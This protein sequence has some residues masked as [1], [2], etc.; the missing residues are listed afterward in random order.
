MK[1]Q[2]KSGP[3]SLIY[4]FRILIIKKLFIQY[5]L[6]TPIYFELKYSASEI[7]TLF[8]LLKWPNLTYRISVASYRSPCI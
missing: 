4:T 7:K 5:Y 6:N 2:Q 3:L 8:F 1:S